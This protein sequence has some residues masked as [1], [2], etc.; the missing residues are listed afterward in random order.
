MA[1]LEWFQGVQGSEPMDLNERE[2]HKARR[3][4]GRARYGSSQ[5]HIGLGRHRESSP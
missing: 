5:N 3:E 4:H 1:D 2:I